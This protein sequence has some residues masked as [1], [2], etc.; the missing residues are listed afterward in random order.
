MGFLRQPMLVTKTAQNGRVS[1]EE[2][3]RAMESMEYEDKDRGSRI[4]MVQSK[5]TELHSFSSFP[6]R[7]TH[8]SG[9]ILWRY[10]GFLLPAD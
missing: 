1:S 7:F 3:N 8:C 5:E 10:I 9:S 4:D 2:Y 6:F